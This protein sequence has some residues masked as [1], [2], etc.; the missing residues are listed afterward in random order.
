MHVANA[1]VSNSSIV[2]THCLSVDNLLSAAW[3]IGF[4]WSCHYLEFV[5]VVKGWFAVRVS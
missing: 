5:A 1:S 4:I 2:I 3:A